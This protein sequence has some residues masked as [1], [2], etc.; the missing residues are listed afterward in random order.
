MIFLTRMKGNKNSNFKNTGNVFI[1][2]N[3]ITGMSQAR[4]GTPIAL[5]RLRL[6]DVE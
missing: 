1:Y 3:N 4:Y 6:E 5:R 2:K